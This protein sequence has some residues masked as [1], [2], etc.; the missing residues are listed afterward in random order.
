M[1]PGQEKLG[2]PG[3][4]GRGLRV[5]PAAAVPAATG[6][7]TATPWPPSFPNLILVPHNPAFAGMNLLV[8]SGGRD[9]WLPLCMAMMQAGK[10][11]GLQAGMLS[12]MQAGV[13]AGMLLGMQAGMPVGM[14]AG[15][16]AG[17]QVGVHHSW[18]TPVGPVTS[19]TAV[20]GQP[21][22]LGLG[23]SLAPGLEG[24]GTLCPHGHHQAGPPSDSSAHTA[25][26]RPAG[27]LSGCAIAGAVCSMQ[28]LSNCVTTAT[29]QLCHHSH[30]PDASP[31]QPLSSCVTAM[32]LTTR[33]HQDCAVEPHRHPPPIPLSLCPVPCPP[34]RSC[35]S[36]GAARGPT[37]AEPG[38]LR[39]VTTLSPPAG[40]PRPGTLMSRMLSGCPCLASPSGPCSEEPG[41][42]AAGGSPAPA[43]AGQGQEGGGRQGDT[44]AA[45][46][47]YG[48]QS[49]SRMCDAVAV[50]TGRQQFAATLLISEM[51]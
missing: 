46:N 41:R 49:F 35:R 25:A 14:M 48:N 37:A 30:C 5:G 17:M 6:A 7:H 45:C 2:V 34:S 26:V 24:W 32:L 9:T 43:G 50:V 21:P 23:S 10:Q 39:G 42:G 44:T 1:S 36:S 29:V 31:P 19:P 15:M 16:M 11:A 27:R 47:C 40:T 4:Q 28:R 33:W 18:H 20:W 38:G 8:S 51:R 12:E 3:Q 13:Q 22:P